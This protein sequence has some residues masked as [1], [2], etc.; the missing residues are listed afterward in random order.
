MRDPLAGF[1][2]PTLYVF[3]DGG[4]ASKLG[5]QAWM[6]E[7]DTARMVTNA[8]GLY[9]EANEPA[10]ELFGLSRD[11]IIGHPAGTFTE[12][13][14]RIEDPQKLWAT[15]EASGELHS[16]AVIHRSDGRVR[17]EFITHRNADG[18]GRHVTWLR[19]VG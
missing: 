2:D 13:D 10:G 11:E 17:V 6:D 5:S 12:P 14:A 3:R 1:G 16:L 9:V 19:P 18:Q 15:L 4:I 8:A 7:P